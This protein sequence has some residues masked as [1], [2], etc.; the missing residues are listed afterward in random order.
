MSIN[1]PYRFML[2][3]IVFLIVGM[4]LGISM[5]TR[6]DF[7]LAPVPRPSQSGRLGDDVPVRPVVSRRARRRHDHHSVGPLL[8]RA[9]RRRASGDRHLRFRR[10]QSRLAVVVIPGALLT[11]VSV[12]VFLWVVW[13]AAQRNL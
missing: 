11:L 5:G 6:E 2:T 9:G 10:A 1:V 3:G 12:L 13:R 7:T 8:D 4:L